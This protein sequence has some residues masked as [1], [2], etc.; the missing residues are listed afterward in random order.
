MVFITAEAYKDAEV[1]T[2]I[3]NTKLFLGKNY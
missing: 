3:V 1:Q 2:I